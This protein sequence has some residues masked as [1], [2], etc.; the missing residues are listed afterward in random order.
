MVTFSSNHFDDKTP[1]LFK[2]LWT[3]LNFEDVTLATLDEK[4]I[5]NKKVCTI[6]IRQDGEENS[7]NI[8]DPVVYKQEFELQEHEHAIYEELIS[9]C[10][11]SDCEDT[12]VDLEGILASTDLTYIEW[13]FNRVF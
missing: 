8:C 9:E 5:T 7:C 2:Q 3:S 4:P 13:S 10:N 6:S 11:Q 1:R 12:P